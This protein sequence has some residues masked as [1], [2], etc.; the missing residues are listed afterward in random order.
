[1]ANRS[2]MIIFLYALWLTR[3]QWV[4]PPAPLIPS[5]DDSRIIGYYA[6]QNKIMILGG[7]TNPRNIIEY[8]IANNSFNLLTNVLSTDILMSTSQ[9]FA[10]RNS[11]L[12]SLGG[13]SGG[14]RQVFSTDLSTNI[15]TTSSVP[16]VPTKVGLLACLTT[17]GDSLF[18]IGGDGNGGSTHLDTLQIFDFIGSSWSNGPIMNQK[19]TSFACAVS[20]ATN[21]LYSIGGE[22]FG[23]SLSAKVEYISIT[24]IQSQSWAYTTNDL[25]DVTRD[26]RAVSYQSDI[27]I[28]GGGSTVDT[29]SHRV[30]VIDT[31]TDTISELVDSLDYGVWNTLPLVVGDL[32]YVFG[33]W[34]YEETSETDRWQYYDFLAT[35][36]P[37]SVPSAAPTSPPT[38]MTSTPSLAPTT[39]G[40]EYI[41]VN[42]VMSSNE[43]QTYCMNTYNT[44]LGTIHSIQDNN[45][46]RDLCVP[47][48]NVSNTLYANGCLF[49]LNDIANERDQ[50]RTGWAWRDGSAFD[51]MNWGENEPNGWTGLNA[52]GEDCGMMQVSGL[53]FDIYCDGEYQSNNNKYWKGVFLCDK[54][55]TPS[56]TAVP[57][58][59]PVQSPVV[60]SNPTGTP[61]TAPTIS[62][63][64][65]PTLAPTNV[66]TTSPITANPTDVPTLVPT[67]IPTLFPTATPSNTPTASPVTSNPSTSPTNVPTTSPI[68][69]NPTNVP[70][71]SPV[72]SHPSRI[73]TTSPTLVPTSS[74][75]ASTNQPTHVPTLAPTLFPTATP[76]TLPTI[77]PTIFPTVTPTR[78]PTGSPNT[79]PTTADPSSVPTTTPTNVPTLTPTSL[80][81]STPT[82]FPTANPSNVP[83]ISP[84]PTLIPTLLPTSTPTLLPTT[85]PTAFPTST[86]TRTPT[87]VPTG[88]PNILPT[89]APTGFPTTSNPSNVPSAS[90]ITGNPTNVPSTPPTTYNP[91]KPPHKGERFGV[92]ITIAFE[93]T[94][95]PSEIVELTVVLQQYALDIMV[96]TTDCSESVEIGSTVQNNRTVLY[97]VIEACGVQSESLLIARQN[98]SVLQ[99]QIIRI[100]EAEVEVQVKGIGNHNPNQNPHG[101][102][103]A[104]G[105]SMD[106]SLVRLI[107]I[108]GSAVVVLVMIVLCV[109]IRR[110]KKHKKGFQTDAQTMGM[111]INDQSEPNETTRGPPEPPETPPGVVSDTLEI[112]ATDGNTE[113]G[114]T[115]DGTPTKGDQECVST[116]TGGATAGHM[117]AGWVETAGA[118][119]KGKRQS[120]RHNKGD[121]ELLYINGVSSTADGT[122]MTGGATAGW[123]AS[124]AGRT[125][126]A[127]AIKKGKGQSKRHSEDWEMIHTGKVTQEGMCDNS[128][129]KEAEPGH[130]RVETRLDE[131]MPGDSNGSGARPTDKST[132]G[133]TTGGTTSGYTE[134]EVD[135]TTC[136]FHDDI[137][138]GTAGGDYV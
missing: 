21:K 126:T 136:G 30:Y 39:P 124:T 103:E 5:A 4:M 50:N 63:T 14:K 85:I 125:Q 106:S 90:P 68:T 120:K 45:N 46:A 49:G 71:T 35:K 3:S 100:N 25:T 79:L 95:P 108:V 31:T 33:G 61:T 58:Q 38:T 87:T 62:P 34:S 92:N 18:V 36:A 64:S 29:Y 109:V 97:A 131:A 56:P 121:S 59:S 132:D 89:T 113:P 130:H 118:I 96:V 42:T 110:R 114:S 43:A 70:T 138:G 53:W 26:L 73:P 52:N 76:S 27:Y 9:A 7:A 12:Y 127:G 19:R 81:T 77:T 8:Y 122:T 123:M 37:S 135:S 137:G 57:T 105:F 119:K 32:F 86:P 6:P 88:S 128:D 112:H 20:A 1:M 74:P 65:T 72:T 94:L 55:V 23:G 47:I 13:L 82:V 98:V 69:A 48:R 15:L 111:I 101:R 107:M 11:I 134:N 2:M 93:G 116:V 40:R 44:S 54:P 117:T 83:T 129:V 104:K 60:T 67:L 41:F 16:T 133:A 51:F 22:I 28:P 115:T 80:P 84:V 10:Q 17:F 91:T 78:L 99:K 24:N 75:T 102:A 66:P